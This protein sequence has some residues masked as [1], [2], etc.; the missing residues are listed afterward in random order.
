[1]AAAADGARFDSIYAVRMR[2][3][4][5]GC[6]TCH[7]SRVWSLLSSAFC[8]DCQPRVPFR[9][10]QSSC[11]YVCH[12]YYAS[13]GLSARLSQVGTVVRGLA[14]LTEQGTNDAYTVSHQRDG[15]MQIACHFYVVVQSGNFFLPIFFSLDS[16]VKAT[17]Y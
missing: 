17:P 8:G 13:V 1:M 3:M 5:N 2:A 10:F 7:T 4:G 16:V 12:V 6:A 9:P 14:I 15:G 11:M